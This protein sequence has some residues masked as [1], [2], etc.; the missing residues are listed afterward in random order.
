[1]RMVLR[2]HVA[3]ANAARRKPPSGR[4][5]FDG[6]R[7]G[8]GRRPARGCPRGCPGGPPPTRT[9]CGWCD[10]PPAASDGGWT[11]SWTPAL[12]NSCWTTRRR[13]RSSPTA[14][15][16]VRHPRRATHCLS[17]GATTHTLSHS[18]TS[19]KGKS[20]SR[21]TSDF[22][23]LQI[24]SSDFDTRAASPFGRRTAHTKRAVDRSVASFSL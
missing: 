4:R 15:P 6:L 2:R 13:R 5:P 8:S 9:A 17:P 21:G 16:G 3:R 7:G 1:M 20:H 10:R 24:R 22:A 18:S 14:G 11:R 23:L 19:S 12:S